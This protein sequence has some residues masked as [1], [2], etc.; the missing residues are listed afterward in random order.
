MKSREFC[1]WLQGYLQNGNKNDIR[2]IS[3]KLNLVFKHD[4][5]PS[6]DDVKYIT[7]VKKIN[8]KFRNEN[9]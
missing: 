6:M 4:I 1:F 9:N 5:N 2:T 8:R 7:K 3:D